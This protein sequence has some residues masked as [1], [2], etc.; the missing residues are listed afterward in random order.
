MWGAG[1]AWADKLVSCTASIRYTPYPHFPPLHPV[2]RWTVNQSVVNPTD[3]LTLRS[4]RKFRCNFWQTTWKLAPN[5][6]PQKKSTNF[7]CLQFKL[8]R[9]LHYLLNIQNS[10]NTKSKFNSSLSLSLCSVYDNIWNKFRQLPDSW[11][12][13]RII[14]SDISLKPRATSSSNSKLAKWQSWPTH[15]IDRLTAQKISKTD[16][17]EVET[18]HTHCGSKAIKSCTNY[19][20]ASIIIDWLVA[21]RGSYNLLPA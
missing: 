3:A 12:A 7:C 19:S 9:M 2:E 8:L 13:I 15:F 21:R 6:Q 14:V 5:C 10:M 11:L 1:S 20:F 18:T 4:T 16:W 17:I